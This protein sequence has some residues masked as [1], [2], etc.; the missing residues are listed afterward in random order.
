MYT[1]EQI[2]FDH[3]DFDRDGLEMAHASEKALWSDEPIH[4]PLDAWEGS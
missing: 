2:D 3:D 4:M 1:L